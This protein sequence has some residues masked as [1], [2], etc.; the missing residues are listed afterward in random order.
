ME[1][2]RFE[3]VWDALE[4][5]PAKAEILKLESLLLM[6]LRNFILDNN[7]TQAKA[8]K[9]LG[10][11]QPRISEIKHNKLHRFTLNSLMEMAIRAGLEVSISFNSKIAA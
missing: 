9:L 2:Q 10:V 5:D 6:R 1:R 3:N 7:L 11:T 8:A 4:P